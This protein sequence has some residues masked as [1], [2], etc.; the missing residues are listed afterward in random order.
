MR[1]EHSFLFNFSASYSQGGYK[2]L[3]EFARWFDGRGGACFAIHPNNTH[4]IDQFPR[5]R[6]FVV[7]RPHLLRLIDDWSYLNEIGAVIGRPELYYAYGIPLYRRFGHVNWSHV[8]NVFVIRR[9]EVPLSLSNRLKFKL[10]AN[11]FHRGFQLADIVSA[12]SRYSL[13]LLDREGIRRPALS[14]NGSDDELEALRC[15]PTGERANVATLVGTISYKDLGESLRVFQFLRRSHPGLKLE[16]IG[17]VCH[18]PDAF[19]T[20]ADIILR[21]ILP[22]SKVVEC[23]RRSRFYISTTQVENSFNAAAEGA[24]LS[25]EAFISDIPPHR[26]LLAGEFADRVPI[27]GRSQPLLHTRRGNLKGVNLRSWNDIVLDTIAVFQDA[28]LTVSP[29]GVDPGRR[30]LASP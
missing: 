15:A 4:L 29:G 6:F 27:P 11:R 25:E 5:N 17:D 9:H 24:F 2:R 18:V 7:R 1:V 13:Q 30:V 19:R 23:L 28:R 8:Q 10:L 21:G 20:D 16:V 3:H 14:V 26:E 12:E 22:R